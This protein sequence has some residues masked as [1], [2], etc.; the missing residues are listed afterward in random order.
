VHFVVQYFSV[1]FHFLSND[2]SYNRDF[3]T[4]YIIDD[5]L[6]FD[7]IEGT[8][9]LDSFSISSNLCYFQK[10]CL[11]MHNDLVISAS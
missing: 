11:H 10:V 3:F 2:K 8:F 7:A 1:N 9:S 5:G 4:I 6:S